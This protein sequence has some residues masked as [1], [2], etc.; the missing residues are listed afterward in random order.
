MAAHRAEIKGRVV[1]YFELGEED[2]YGDEHMMRYIQRNN[3]HIDGCWGMHVDTALPAGKI[4]LIPGGVYSGAMFYGVTIVPEEGSNANPL[5]CAVSI[6]NGLNTARMRGVSPF[7][8]A[9]VTTC[10][11]RTEGEV[12]QSHIP[13][14]FPEPAAFI[15]VIKQV[16]SYIGTS[17]GSS[18]IPAKPSGVQ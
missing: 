8:P 15:I 18:P 9:T 7:E 12:W 4:G 10:G 2:G 11:F 1:L 14:V 5:D 6:V 16:S 3:I 13:V 17:I